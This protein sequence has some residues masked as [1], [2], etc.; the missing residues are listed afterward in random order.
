MTTTPDP[1]KKTIEPDIFIERKEDLLVSTPKLSVFKTAITFWRVSLI[2]ILVSFGAI[3]DCFA[4]IVPNNVVGNPGFI[5]QFG[6][7]RG[8]TGE[9]V[10]LNPSTLSNWNLVTSL[11]TFIG[12]GIGNMVSDRF[13]RKI[14]FYATTLTLI[15][16]V[17]LSLT[18]NNGTAWGARGAFA[19]I[20]QGLLQCSLI[21]YLGEIAP[22]RVRGAFLSGYSFFWNLGTLVGGIALYIT[23]ESDPLDYKRVFYAQFVFLG[24]FA[25]G[26]VVA[27]ESPW[28]LTR[29][30]HKDKAIRALERLY[31]HVSFYDVEL[32]YQTILTTIEAERSQSSLNAQSSDWRMYLD[33]FK[34]TNRRRTFVAC[35]P[36]LTQAFSGVVLFFGYTVYFFQQ[37]GYAQPFQANL[38]FAGVCLLGI[39]A[40]FFV[41]DS[42]GRRPVLILG[43]TI[44][45]ACCWAL[46][47]L[48]FKEDNSGPGLV[49]VACIWVFFFSASISPM[50]Y[51]YVAEIPTQRLRSKVAAIAFGLYAAINLVYAYIVPY[52]LSPLEWGWGLKTGE[53][54]AIDW[55]FGLT[56]Q[57]VYSLA[58]FAHWARLHLA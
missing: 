29:H 21:P 28:W 20:S 32:E 50:G 8:P 38:I 1:E 40:S 49:L 44:C 34:G 22:P 58:L 26:L 30:G 24:V 11:G 45:C 37:A 16:A 52:M 7:V 33:C 56:S 55:H 2:G 23:T 57:Q 17:V 42:I 5:Q 43:A 10:A 15:V 31:G 36:I 48:G 39:V 25:A 13:G 14:A 47:G 41:L 3:F 9:I 4:L 27:P 35:V 46:G 6:T 12:L 51:N 18:A 53:S 19:G 54:V